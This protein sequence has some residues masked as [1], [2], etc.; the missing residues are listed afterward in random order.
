MSKVTKL[1]ELFVSETVFAC[2]EVML[3][4]GISKISFTF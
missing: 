1:E 2:V 4:G 3:G